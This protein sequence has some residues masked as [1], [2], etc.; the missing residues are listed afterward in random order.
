MLLKNAHHINFPVHTP[1]KNLSV[2][3]K[4][5]LWKGCKHFEGIQDYFDYLQ[6]IIS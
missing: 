5:I 3:D 2:Q 4:K 1:Y 6:S